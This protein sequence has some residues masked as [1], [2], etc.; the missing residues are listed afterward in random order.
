MRRF[1]S[2]IRAQKI[3]TS[4]WT[5]SP[6]KK[7][8]GRIACLNRWKM[9]K[10]QAKGLQFLPSEE[11]SHHW[12][13]LQLR[14]PLLLCKYQTLC[15]IPSATLVEMLSLDDQIVCK[16]FMHSVEKTVSWMSK[17][18]CPE[19]RIALVLVPPAVR[20]WVV[21]KSIC[22]LYQTKCT[23]T[24]ASVLASQRLTITVSSHRCT[25]N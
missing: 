5:V 11:L 9:S 2:T 22:H 23:Y 8:K 13:A 18:L 10:K 21:N 6:A 17:E 4:E 24:A 3:L 15:E 7:I 12:L 14:E 20:T 1:L 16:T 25:T 19:T